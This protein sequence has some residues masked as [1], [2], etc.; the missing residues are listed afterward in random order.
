MSFKCL[1]NRTCDIELISLASPDNFGGRTEES[2]TL[3]TSLPCR[4]RTRNAGE[5]RYSSPEYQYATHSLYLEYVKLP[6][7]R[8]R[9]KTGSVYYDVCGRIELGGAQKYLCLYL[10]RKTVCA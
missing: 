8:L 4:L 10:E 5:K 7:G 9:I 3:F 6:K 1:L 2:K